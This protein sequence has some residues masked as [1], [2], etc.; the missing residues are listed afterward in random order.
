MIP[1]H[2]PRPL[3]GATAMAWCRHVTVPQDRRGSPLLVLE[4]A[5]MAGSVVRE[6]GPSHCR[7]PAASPRARYA[8]E[9]QVPWI[10][11][12]WYSTPAARGGAA[13]V[14][15]RCCC[16]AVAAAPTAT[17]SSEMSDWPWP[18]L[19]RASNSWIFDASDC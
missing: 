12:T 6:Q 15:R 7:C 2:R 11:T 1:R 8:Q 9:Q 14:A 17:G 10:R 19:D 5:R 16:L 3:Y 4:P 13:A 18:D